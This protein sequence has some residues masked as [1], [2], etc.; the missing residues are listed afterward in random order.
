MK[1]ISWVLLIF[2]CALVFVLSTCT[3]KSSPSSPAPTPTT[4]ASI[5]YTVTGSNVPCFTIAYYTPDGYVNNLVDYTLPYTSATY[6]F[7]SGEQ[8]G[9]L[10]TDCYIN[11]IEG[12]LTV[13]IYMNGSV[14]KTITSDVYPSGTISET[15]S[16]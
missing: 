3:N 2:C 10:V 1:K 14:W 8:I 5:Y 7:T 16:F 4:T 6:T 15:G 13:D 11:T 12:T 9:I